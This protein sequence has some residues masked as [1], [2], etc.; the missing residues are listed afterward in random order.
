MEL[1]SICH[2]HCMGF[3]INFVLLL[4][5]FGIYLHLV[6]A[7]KSSPIIDQPYTSHELPPLVSS[8]TLF[9]TTCWEM[10]ICELTLAVSHPHRSRTG[11]SRPS[12]PSQLW[13][14]GSLF[15]YDVIIYL[16]CTELLWYSKDVT[17]VSV[18]WFIICVRL[19]PSTPGDYVRA[20]VPKTRVWHITNATIFLIKSVWVIW[21]KSSKLWRMVMMLPYFCCDRREMIF[22]TISASPSLLIPIELRSLTIRFKW[23]YISLTSS[24]S[25]IIKKYNHLKLGTILLTDIWCAVM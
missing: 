6:T 17:F 16:F 11:R 25:F 24:F 1:N 2:L 14:D 4:L 19:G 13:V 20:R 7:N 23:E 9:S 3:I 21:L 22:R 15:P 8:C 5:W 12:S 18:P 10:N